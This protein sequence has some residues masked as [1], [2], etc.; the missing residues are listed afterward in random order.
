MFQQHKITTGNK[1]MNYEEIYE[2][3]FKEHSSNKFKLLRH[4]KK[5]YPEFFEYLESIHGKGLKLSEYLYL[6][7]HSDER[8]CKNNN[9]KKFKTMYDGYGFCGPK[10]KCQCSAEEQSSKLKNIH[11]NRS[12]EDKKNILSK[13]KS[14]NLERYGVDNAGKHDKF[15]NKMKQ[16]NLEKY[17]SEYYSQTDEYNDKIRNTSLEKYGTE[18]FTQNEA[19]KE[20]NKL[21]NEERYGGQMVQARQKAEEIFGGNVFGSDWFKTNRDEFYSNSIG[22]SHPTKSPEI[23]EKVKAKNIE[24]YGV[25][26]YMKSK[27]NIKEFEKIIFEKYG[28]RNVLFLDAV[29]EKIKNTLM[30]KYGVDNYSKTA[31]FNEKIKN[32]SLEKFNTNHYS[33]TDEYKNRVK[34]TSMDKYGVDNYKKLDFNKN[35]INIIDSE[36]LFQEKLNDIGVYKFSKLLNCDISTVYRLA[37]NMGLELPNIYRSRYEEIIKDFLNE[38]NIEF[39]SNYRK[40]LKNNKE[41]DFYF[42][43]HNLAIEFCGNYWHSELSG[44]KTRNYH[45]DKWKELEDNGIT[46]FTIFEDE[47]LDNEEFWFNKIKYALNLFKTNRKIYAR[48]C[49]INIINDYKTKK[50]FLNKYHIQGDLSTTLS[51]GLYYEDELISIMSFNKSRNDDKQIELVRFCSIDDAN[52]IGAAGKLLNYFIKNYS[53]VYDSIKSFSDNR[54]SDG[55]LY[56]KLNF[57]LDK[58]IPPDYT[59]LKNENRLKRIH[60][61]SFSKTKI[62]ER[63]KLDEEY[64]NKKTEWE[65]MQELGFDRIWDCGKKRWIMKL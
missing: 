45:Y 37:A 1:L 24:K 17:G 44:Q 48:K 39:K 40:L 56:E 33:Q 55:N 63:F 10:S 36:I 6:Y 43:N 35:M 30:E 18:H 42:P 58:I 31:E 23:K 4:A 5:K 34:Q 14:T 59:Y 9:F 60:K 32:T 29:K 11:S 26:N 53:S 12:D 8:L 65:L 50:E 21:T 13:M 7:K 20:K 16:T 64:V 27:E 62:K 19:V 57:T 46:L 52:V 61:Y 49:N 25:D 47:F 54:Y 22:Y 28:V 41:V 15:K 2:E 51:L 38:N 3:I